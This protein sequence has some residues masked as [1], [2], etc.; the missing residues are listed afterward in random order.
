MC[1]VLFVFVVL[2]FLCLLVCLVCL[3]VLLVMLML[4]QVVLVVLECEVNIFIGSK[5][6]GNMFLGVLV[7]FGLIQVSLIGSYYLGWCY[8]DEKIRGFGYF[9]IFGVGCWEQGGQVLVL[10][11]IGLIGLG[12]DFDIGNVKQ[13]DYKV[14]V[15]IYIYD[16]EIGQVGYYKVC[17]ISYGGIDVEV[18]VCICVVV[19]CY[20]FSQCSGDGYVFVNVGQ[21]NECYLVIGSVVDV[22]GDCVVEGK[23]VIKS[24]CGGYQ[25]IIWF[26][27][28]FD[29]LF[30]V[31][32]IWGEG[33]G[34]LGVC[35]SME[36]EQ[37][38]NGVWFSFDL[39]KGQLVMVVSVILYVDVEGVCINLCVEG[40]QNGVLFGFDCMC[41]LFQ[42]FWCEQLGWV[43]VQG[44]I[45]D[46]C[47]VF[48]S[49][50]YYVLLQ[51]MIGNDV[52]GC[53]CGYDDS[54][55]CVD[56]W[57]YYEYFLLWDIY[58]VQNQWLVLICLDVVCDIG[59]I[60]LVIDEQVGWLL[61]WG[62]VNFE[63]NI[64]IGDLVMLFMVDLWCFG[65]FQGCEL[66]VW[67]VLCCNVFGMLLLN[68][69][70]VGCFGNLIYLIKGYVV[71]DCVF[72]FK[73]MDVDLYYGGLVML[74]YVLVDCVFL[75]MVDGLGYV[76][77]VVILC[78]CGC[79]WCKVW[80]LQVCDVEIGFIGFLCLCIEDGQWYIL[81]DGYYSLCLYYGFY[82]GMVWQYQWLVQQDVL[83]LVEVMDGC[84]Q[85]GCCL[86][87]FFVMDVLQVDLF[88][89]VC[90]VWVV[91]LYSYYNQFCYNLNN[92]LDLYL[93]WLYMLIGQL[94]KIVVV[95]CVVQ[96][97]FI[98]VFN[99]VIGNDDFGMMLVWY[100]FSVIGVYLVVL[101]SG[102]FLLYMLCFSKVEVDMGNGCILCIDVLGVDGCC[103]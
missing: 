46:D 75:Q 84:E 36:G 25:Y 10:L 12:G 31:Y 17:L 87:V 41:V 45:V 2:L 102:Q 100:L 80:D 96:Q 103:L 5:D 82:E 81:F 70:M 62:Y 94:W 8:D 86:D 51:L 99:G 69:C 97:L 73:G 13:F 68:L 59:C 27:I 1:L 3:F 43:C 90:K 6:D 60:L 95:V 61:C 23:L 55:Y 44:G 15:L 58:C 76:Q 9:F 19:E 22:V 78:E 77:D 89:V 38:L 49:V 26:C 88:N 34:L 54:I 92:E 56:G 57:I 48:Y 65:V 33:G 98:N 85:V 35:Y 24:F 79:N 37:K 4:L 21:V 66:Q 71:Y 53:Y 39:I 16:G 67:D 14:Y 42:Q 64:M 101:G 63:I 47:V 29:C 7:L 91:G 50:V 18:I 72:L 20:I 74:E 30:K 11:V 32:G 83:G 40:M 93:L 28:E 52:D